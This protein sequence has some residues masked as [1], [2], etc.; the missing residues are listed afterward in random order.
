MLL[1]C[2]YGRWKCQP[3]V[4]FWILPAQLHFVS[5]GIYQFILL[6]GVLLISASIT[7]R[8]H[9][10]KTLNCRDSDNYETKRFLMQ[11]LCASFDCFCQHKPWLETFLTSP[12]KHLLLS[13]LQ[14]LKRHRP[15]VLLM[16]TSDN[17]HVVWLWIYLWFA[18]TKSANLL[19]WQLL[20]TL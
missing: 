19:S 6:H 10:L 1:L 14:M 17:K 18:G 12:L 11:Q 16:L 3:S 4:I 9:D 7:R 5:S 20:T 8:K 2:C 15:L 13:P